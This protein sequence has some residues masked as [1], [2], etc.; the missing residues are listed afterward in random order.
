M[1]VIHR[2]ESNLIDGGKHADNL[3][4]GSEVPSAKRPLLLRIEADFVTCTQ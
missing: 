3:L 4:D 2:A 1:G